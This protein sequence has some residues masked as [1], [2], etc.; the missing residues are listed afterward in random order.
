[1]ILKLFTLKC[2]GGSSIK[3]RMRGKATMKRPMFI[4]IGILV[5]GSCLFGQRVEGVG[6]IDYG[7]LPKK[8]I[9]IPARTIPGRIIPGRFIPGRT[10]PG[11]H[12]PGR[13]SSSGWIDAID[14]PEIVIPDINV[15]EVIVPTVYVSEMTYQVADFSGIE[16]TNIHPVVYKNDNAEPPKDY[17]H[18]ASGYMSKKDRDERFINRYHYNDPAVLSLF[19]GADYDY[20]G[21][22]SWEQ[23]EDFQKNLFKDFKYLINTTARRPDEFIR[24]GGGECFDWALMASAFLDYWGWESYLAVF[25]VGRHTQPAHAICMVH[26]P[27][28]LPGDFTYWNV[29][30]QRTEQGDSLT[31]G[32]YVPVDYDEVGRLSNAVKPGWKLLYFLTPSKLYGTYM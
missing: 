7:S 28:S 10:I 2:A 24:Q 8:T 13:N 25:A 15:P 1:M 27:L 4:F 5:L 3:Q 23:L 30:G 17:T 12:I 18:D 9:T 16:R 19:A 22:L 6:Q 20:T 29:S 14:I 31:S 26:S 11:R 21:T 32:Q